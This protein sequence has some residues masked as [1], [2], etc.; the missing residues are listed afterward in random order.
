M[1]DLRWL[2]GMYAAGAAG[3]IDGLALHS[4]GFTDAPAAPPDP[5]RLNFRR[6]EL[7]RDIMLRP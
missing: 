3:W 4:Y 1:H 5:A 7:Y 6:V 2:E